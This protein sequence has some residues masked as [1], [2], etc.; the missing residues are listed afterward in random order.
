MRRMRIHH[1]RRRK[2]GKEQG[3][4]KHFFIG[5]FKLENISVKDTPLGG[6]PDSFLIV[7]SDNNESST[8][9]PSSVQQKSLW[10]TQIQ[11]AKIEQN[12]RR[13]FGVDLNTLMNTQSE[14]GKDVPSFIEASLERLMEVGLEKE[15]IFRLSG[16]RKD[17]ENCKSLVDSGT[18]IDFKE[19][20]TH[21]LTGF[22]KMWIRDLPTSL[23]PESVWEQITQD[24][25]IPNLKRIFE[26]YPNVYEKYTLQAV[27]KVLY[28]VTLNHE[29]NKM[30]SG[31]L[32][33][34]FGPLLYR[35][36]S[37]TDLQLVFPLVSKII[38]NYES[39]FS[40]IETEREKN[41]TIGLSSLKKERRKLGIEPKRLSMRE[42]SSNALVES[43]PPGGMD[44]AGIGLAEIVKQGSLSK[45][46]AKRRNWKERWFVL[47]PKFLYY[48]GNRKDSVSKGVI[49]LVNAVV[50]PSTHK[51]YCFSISTKGRE[52]LIAAKSEPEM[53]EW[54]ELI[55]S[56]NRPE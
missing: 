40:G 1:H 42:N 18:E 31:N 33:I 15:G 44:S 56:C 28:Y 43:E 16:N 45:K 9:T 21:C 30:Q 12:Q 7:N 55:R 26:S 13:V 17:I 36:S 11:S 5:P 23:I 52:F 19:K 6:D 37:A 39:I 46:G 48:F 27:M 24:D 38:D 3:S 54:I 50:S 51:D 2:L 35:D 20:D 4:M 29:S 41:V 22:V 14:K 25:S 53:K 8:L 47:K 49:T 34:V 32:S 10:Y